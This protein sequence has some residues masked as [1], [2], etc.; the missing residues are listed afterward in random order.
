MLSTIRHFQRGIMIAIAIVVVIAFTFFGNPGDPSQASNENVLNINGD[1]ISSKEALRLRSAFSIL[2]SLGMSDFAQFL[3]GDQRL[4]RD[5]TDFAVNLTLFREEAKKLGVVATPE[6]IKDAKRNLIM[7]QIGAMTDDRLKSEVLSPVGYSLADLYDLLGDYVAYQQIRSLL[8]SGV[9]PLDAEI[10]DAYNR[11]FATIHGSLVKIDR[12]KLEE[13]AE[14]AIT[15]E[16][17]AA[18]F[19]K[20][21]KAAQDEAA[22]VA[23]G[24][25]SPLE[26]AELKKIAKYNTKRMRAVDLV[27][28][29]RPEL[30]E[31]ATAEARA[32]ADSAYTNRVDT[33]TDEFAIDG[34]NFAE[35]A[36]KNELVFEALEPFA[37]SDP[38]ES[39]KEDYTILQRIFSN[40]LN[41]IRPVSD[42]FPLADETY[43]I[44]RLR[45]DIEPRPL[46]L[47]E[48]REDIIAELKE[49][50][51]QT[52]I[53]EAVAEARS[54]ITEAL[55]AGKS[56]AE[57]AKAA[58]LE[59]EALPP[60][61]NE[62][63]PK[64]LDAAGMIAGIA[65]QL[66]P[67][68][69]G[70]N[71]FPFGENQSAL[72]YVEKKELVKS[73]DEQTRRDTIRTQL[74]AGQTNRLMKAWFASA[75][76]KAEIF[77][78]F[79]LKGDDESATEGKGGDA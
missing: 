49:Q 65:A 45:E 58:G 56:I 35:V 74:I 24:Q 13:A 61:S 38:P 22:S 75:Y 73:P 15:D 57:A 41:E 54:K 33:L 18:H 4:D 19:E 76:D 40:T 2:Y 8:E 31:D 50:G 37:P 34:K 77:K 5:Y 71:P 51:L 68:E 60:F 26:E 30:P 69:L 39:I 36:K 46:T 16:Q 72:V 42:P 28:F 25:G 63:P 9:E 47:E 43:I 66:N 29:P 67:G 62:D 21:N 78:H 70:A 44:L 53:N 52:R 7:Y 27:R 23:S 3:Y 14:A 1:P 55:E 79:R 10:E 64:D 32:E 20:E 59:V 17:I 12:T 11:Q 48:A 6:Q